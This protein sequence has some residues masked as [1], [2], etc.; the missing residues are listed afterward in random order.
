MNGLWRQQAAAL[1]DALQHI[2]RARG[3][4]F[5]NIMV[6]AIALA[7]PIAGLTLLENLQPVAGRLAVEP[8]VSVFLA[9]DTPRPAAVALGLELRRVLDAS[10]GA[11]AGAGAGADTV[12]VAGAGAATVANAG[13]DKDGTRARVTFVPKEM[14]LKTLQEKHGV[15]DAVA[16]LGDNPLPD[17]YLI[18]LADFDHPAAAGRLEPLVA[19]LEK[20]SGV[21]QVQVD[22]AWVR[23]LAALLHLLRTALL[24]LAATL[25]VVVVAVAFN[26]IRLQVM[27]QQE[28]IAVARLVGATDRFIYRPFF[29]T[30][31]LL[32]SSAGLLALGAV[33]LALL[34]I[35]R[36]VDDLARQYA[37]QFTLSP[38]DW[39]QSLSLLAASALLGLIGS[40][41][42]VRRHLRQP[43]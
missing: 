22:S 43:G 41:L 14:A 31:A 17:A 2:G 6:I 16:A 18:T 37:T 9:A 29:Y 3:S 21:E 27:T 13:A 4:F 42:S 33:A 1:A 5:L 32:G 25:A 36:A 8:T 19:Q 39:Q 38:L 28:E 10:S 15:A 26:T 11:G 35:N 20:L 40:A 12:A 23:R 24:L 7:L 30:G 34:P